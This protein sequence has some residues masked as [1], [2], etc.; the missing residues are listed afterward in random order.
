M[1]STSNVQEN[2]IMYEVFPAAFILMVENVIGMFGNVSIV[3]ATLRNSKLQTTCNW[4]IAINALADGG[5]Q[6]AQYVLTYYLFTGINYV[7]LKTCWHLQFI[8]YM[9]FSSTLIVTILVGIDRLITILFPLLEVSGTY[10]KI[11]YLVGMSTI[12][13]CY[14]AIWGA[15]S[16]GHMMLVADT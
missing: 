9:F 1:N 11:L 12:P 15:I 7:E 14:S 8:P 4:L 10:N 16:Y 5:T 6:L 13:M 3:W 2:G